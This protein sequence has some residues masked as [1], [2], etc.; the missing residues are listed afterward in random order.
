LGPRD[1]LVIYQHAARNATWREEAGRKL[2]SV[3]GN[4]DVEVFNSPKIAWDVV[5]LAGGNKQGK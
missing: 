3:C 2:V 4:Q 1:W 5:F